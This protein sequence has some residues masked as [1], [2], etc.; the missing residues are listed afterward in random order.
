MEEGRKKGNKQKSSQKEERKR[1]QASQPAS[2]RGYIN[3]KQSRFHNKEYFQGQRGSFYNT[4]EF[5]LLRSY[6]NPKC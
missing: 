1:K 5:N 4:G 6:N 3:I 2:Q